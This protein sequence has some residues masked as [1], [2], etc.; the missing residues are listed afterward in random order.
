MMNT[1][2]KVKNVKIQSP[3]VSGLIYAFCSLLIITLIAS[4][5]LKLTNVAEQSV[6]VSVFIIHGIAL[7]LGGFVSGKR[8]GEKGWYHGGMMGMIY[9]IIVMLIG[10]LGFDS[11]LMSINSLIFVVLSFIAASIG[12]ILGVNM[13]K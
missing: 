1:M 8:A 4:L 5:L 9:F 3:M 2:E 7:T 13:T 6:F 12:G 11:V 10:F